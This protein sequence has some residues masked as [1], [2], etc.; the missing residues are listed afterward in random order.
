MFA[1]TF[2]ERLITEAD[3]N[4]IRKNHQSLV[5]ENYKGKNIE[6]PKLWLFYD[7]DTSSY[8]LV[9]RTYE[10][11]EPKKRK[12]NH[13]IIDDLILEV[14]PNNV[15]EIFQEALKKIESGKC[16]LWQNNKSFIEL[17]ECG[18]PHS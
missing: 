7:F 3:L 11:S 1:R 12:F 5:L 6:I 15:S 9:R 13:V 2:T 14:V 17:P 18:K 4:D 8:I 10:N 16:L